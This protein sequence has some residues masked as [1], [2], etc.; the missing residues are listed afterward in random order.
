MFDSIV[1]NILVLLVIAILFISYFLNMHLFVVYCDS[2]LVV[3]YSI[4]PSI[5]IIFFLYSLSLHLGNRLHAVVVYTVNIYVCIHGIDEFDE[6]LFIPLISPC[7][8][9]MG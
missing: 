7:A 8:Q 2:K 9:C 4:R 5:S 3:I 1:N 6:S